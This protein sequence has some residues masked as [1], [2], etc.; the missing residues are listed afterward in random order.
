[1]R[2]IERFL[3]AL[4]LCMCVLP[5]RAYANVEDY[6][7]ALMNPEELYQY[8]YVPD[9]QKKENESSIKALPS[10]ATTVDYIKLLADRFNT[11][12]WGSTDRPL[13]NFLTFFFGNSP[14]MVAMFVTPAICM[15][16]MWWG[17]RKTYRM[18]VKVFR[19]GKLGL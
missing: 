11:V 8:E 4:V 13:H 15:C 7:T 1:M 2:R 3:L 6:E 10:D 19:G 14:N 16:F 17:L 9:V 5:T 12:T 18:Y